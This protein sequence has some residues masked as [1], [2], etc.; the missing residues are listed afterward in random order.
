MIA[1]DLNILHT[2]AIALIVVLLTARIVKKKYGGLWKSLRAGDPL[3]DH[4]AAGGFFEG[5]RIPARK[6]CPNCAE[7]LP[8]SALICDACDYN[9]LAMRPERGQKL[10]PSPQPTA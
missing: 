8:L 7:Q 2:S 9:F 4:C 5:Q 1:V 6:K 10:L 3:T